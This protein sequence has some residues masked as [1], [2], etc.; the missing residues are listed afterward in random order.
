MATLDVAIELPIKCRNVT[1]LE[2]EPYVVNTPVKFKKLI[3]PDVGN[4]KYS[5]N[6]KRKI[7][8]SKFITILIYKK[9]NSELKSTFYSYSSIL[10]WDV[11]GGVIQKWPN[12]LF[13]NYGVSGARGAVGYPPL[14]K[15]VVLVGGHSVTCEQQ[16]ENIVH[17]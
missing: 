8:Y 5:V 12:W 15:Y 13:V 10:T 14:A 9:I 16:R 4:K 11:L 17:P 1:L 6:Y 3:F 2:K 7:F